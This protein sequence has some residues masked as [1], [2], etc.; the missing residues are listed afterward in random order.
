MLHS[1]GEGKHGVE[2]ELGQDKRMSLVSLM[3]VLLKRVPLSPVMV[4]F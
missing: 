3:A 1:Q 4:Y 2:E